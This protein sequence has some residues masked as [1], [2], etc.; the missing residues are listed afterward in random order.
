[1]FEVLGSCRKVTSSQLKYIMF[2][3]HVLVCQDG[4]GNSSSLNLVKKETPLIFSR[5]Q[6]RNSAVVEH[7]MHCRSECRS[8]RRLFAWYQSCLLQSLYV[9]SS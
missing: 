7:H 2:L 8:S 5:P 9:D 3:V 4:Q 6:N 1:M